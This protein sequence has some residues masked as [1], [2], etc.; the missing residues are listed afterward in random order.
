[1]FQARLVTTILRRNKALNFFSHVKDASRVSNESSHVSPKFFSRS[2]GY[3]FSGRSYFH[4]FRSVKKG[5]SCPSSRNMCTTA[6]IGPSNEGLKMLV[7]AGPHAQKMVG[8]WLFG[9]AAWVFSM[10]ILGGITRLTRS[11]LSMTDWK[12]TGRLPPLSEEEWLVEFEKYKQSPEY[13]RV[14]KG[15]SVDD[16]K[17]IYWMEYAHRMWGRGLGVMFALP[18]TYFLRKGWITFRLGLRLSALFALGA[19]QGFVGWWMVKSGLE[20]PVSEY[21]QPRVSP[22][23]LAAHLTSAFA[24]YCGLLW[25]GLSVV[26]PDPPTGSLAWVHGA[27]K[28]RKLALPLSVLVGITAISGAFVAGNDAGHA[29]NTFP[30]MGDAWIPDDIFSMEPLFCNFFENTSTVQLDHRILATATLLSISGLW[31][32][33]R[34][35]DMHPAVRS[36]IGSTMGMAA[37]QVTLGITTLLSYV[38]VSLGTAHQAGALTLL[39]FIILLTHTVRRPSPMLLKSLGSIP[40]AP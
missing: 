32:T 19:G 27:A 30:K 4:V 21:V 37:L 2:S 16:F 34:K 11:G 18:L 7:T 39:T 29:Y 17:F 25:T 20:E 38:P 26:M 33:T 35:L 12:F 23:R 8:I 36:L 14:N 15:L 31:W 5:F 40:R 1:M 22:Y 10:V 28:I 24:I 6:S 3:S 9:S 13:K